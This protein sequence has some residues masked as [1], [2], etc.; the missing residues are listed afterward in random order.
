MDAE[1]RGR[2]TDAVLRALGRRGRY[3]LLQVNLMLLGA[4]ISASQ[5]FNN[6]FIGKASSLPDLAKSWKRLWQDLDLR[7]ITVLE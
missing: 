4:L 5:L 6:V 7:C 2:A 1:R 3:Q